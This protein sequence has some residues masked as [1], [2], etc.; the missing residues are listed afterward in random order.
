MGGEEKTAREPFQIA[1]RQAGGAT[2][3]AALLECSRAYV[4]MIVSGSRRPGLNVAFRIE[5]VFGIP[6]PDWVA[7]APSA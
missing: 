1:V 5:K 3:A 2:K 7:V 4:D 6:M